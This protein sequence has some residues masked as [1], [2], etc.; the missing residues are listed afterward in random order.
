M[1]SSIQAGWGWPSVL[2]QNQSLLKLTTDVTQPHNTYIPSLQDQQCYATEK[3][4]LD[5]RHIPK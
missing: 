2:M 4:K 3:Q 5:L 1:P